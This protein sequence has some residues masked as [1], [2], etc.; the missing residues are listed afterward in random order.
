VEYDGEIGVIGTTRDSEQIIAHAIIQ[1]TDD[2]VAADIAVEYIERRLLATVSRSFGW[3]NSPFACNYLSD[4]LSESV[5][6]VGAL[7]LGLSLGGEPVSFWFGLGPR[8]TERIDSEWRRY[9]VEESSGAEVGHGGNLSMITIEVAELA[10]PPALVIDYMRAGTVIDLQVPV[11]SK[12]KLRKSGRIWA[13]GNLAT[14]NGRFAVQ[15]AELEPRDMG[16]PDGATRVTVE[17]C[18]TELDRDG[19][20]EH[21]QQGAELL[22]RTPLGNTAFLVIGGEKVARAD[23][24]IIDG[25]YA[26]TVH[27]KS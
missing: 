10:V 25:N 27:H 3:G 9:I 5:E 26:V 22:T 11:S 15:I 2:S 8:V 7:K 4:E 17:L 23:V 24:G 12:V 13:T 1:N 19:I 18:Q 16:F 20:I 14:F 6:V 21:S